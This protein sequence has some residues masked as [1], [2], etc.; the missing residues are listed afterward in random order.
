MCC[1]VV[2]L[3]WLVQQLQIRIQRNNAETLRE[4]EEQFLTDRS[5]ASFG[6]DDPPP[7][8]PIDLELAKEEEMMESHLYGGGEGDDETLQSN[9]S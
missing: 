9:E 5:S 8:D 6:M 1:E 3:R 2:F 4:L 7:M